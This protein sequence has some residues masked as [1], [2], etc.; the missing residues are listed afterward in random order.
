M[1]TKRIAH[2]AVGMALLAAGSFSAQAATAT[3]SGMN[4]GDG[5][6]LLFSVSGTTIDGVDGN[7]LNVGLNS[8]KA[9]SASGAPTVL[10]DTFSVNITAPT[11][12]YITSVDYDEVYSYLSSTGVAAI[13]LSVVANGV[14]SNPA[15]AAFAFSNGANVGISIPQIVY[16]PGVESVSLSISNSLFA[17]ALSNTVEIEKLS[18]TLSVGLT[19]VPLPPALGLLGAA[20]IGLTTIGKRRNRVAA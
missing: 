12:F 16:G 20:L 18:A 4:S 2:L 1:K 19:P 17:Y 14:A 6:D 13:T 3:F 5:T 9:V 8:F 7:I 10:V 11:G 15:S